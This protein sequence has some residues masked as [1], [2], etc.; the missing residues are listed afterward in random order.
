[1]I[2]IKV[3]KYTSSDANQWDT[4]VAQAKNAT[5]LFKRAFMD[6]HSDRFQDFSLLV[7]KDETLFAVLPAN[8]VNDTLYS[9]QGLSYGGLVLSS[10]AKFNHVLA[11]FSGVLKFLVSEGITLLKIKM[12]PKIYH[13]LPSD[14]MDYLCF[15]LGAK[16]YRTDLSSTINL[17]EENMLSR[18]RKA[19]IKRGLANQLVVR[20]ENDFELFWD[21]LLINKL[22]N[23]HKTAP[24][25]TLAEIQLL[26]KR[27][28]SHIKQFNVYQYNELVAGT[29]I[30]ETKYVA[31]SQYI[32][33]NANKNSL[34]ALDFLHREIIIYYRSRQQRYFDFGISNESQGALV[35]KGLQYW[36]E[37]FGASSIMQQFYSIETKKITPT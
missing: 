14:E 16:L 12:L 10:K 18:D 35:N 24:V 5:F 6:Y 22:K 8:V 30:F 36:K 27:F 20:E 1:L 32:A 19:G 2:T 9:H 33:S 25:H 34:G 3:R 23:K 11:V 29:T 21:T 17:A 26:K 4:F 28:P 13:T 15:L 7:F 37:G 31:H